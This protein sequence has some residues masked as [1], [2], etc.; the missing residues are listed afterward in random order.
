MADALKS[1]TNPFP[2]ARYKPQFAYR[3]PKGFRDETYLVPF[4]FSVPA[5][6]LLHLGFPWQLDDDVP[7]ILRGIIFPA[8]GTAQ[9]FFNTIETSP[10]AFPGLCRITDTQGNPL[11]DGLVLALGAWGQSGF[12]DAVT[13]T[14]INAFG[15][16]IEPEVI[17]APGG[18]VIFDFQLNTNA[19]AAAFVFNV[20]AGEEIVF[21]ARVYG[22]AGNA[23]SIQLV[24]PGAPNVPLSVAVAGTAVAVTLATDGASV[25]TSTLADVAAAI[26]NDPQASLLLAAVLFYPEGG[27]ALAAALAVSPLT[28]GA[29][30][31]DTPV[32][33][34]GTLIGV[35][36][37]PDC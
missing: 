36:R 26:N 2:Q 4:K 17:C 19:A 25:I 29:A 7:Y 13:P 34:T 18:A 10:I 16:P 33:L 9:P 32:E 3:T 37:F 24:D 22:V 23:Y 31:T 15:F 14:G 12:S 8:I 30:A 5:D 21:S 35:K 28:G 6:G 1:L 11:S 20:G 27:G